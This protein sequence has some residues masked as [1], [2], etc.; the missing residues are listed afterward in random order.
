MN[1]ITLFFLLIPFFSISQVQIGQK[2]AGENIYDWSAKN[3]Y[4]SNDGT[5][6]AIGAEQ[7]NGNGN[8]SGHVRVYK[9]I[10]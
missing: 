5:V 4:L 6:L 10:A 7:N 2:I 8:R 9:K 3:I 1:K